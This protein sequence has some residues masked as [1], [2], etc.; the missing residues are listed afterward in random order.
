VVIRLAKMVA[1]AKTLGPQVTPVL[2]LLVMLEQIV[3]MIPM[4]VIPN[5][6]K[7]MTYVPL[8]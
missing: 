7:T 6:V 5:H 8:L 1:H 3:N 4:H 2:V